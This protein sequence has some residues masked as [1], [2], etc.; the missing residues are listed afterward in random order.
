MTKHKI[1]GYK[2]SIDIFNK[3]VVKQEIKIKGHKNFGCILYIKSNL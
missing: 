3:S 2:N 1:K